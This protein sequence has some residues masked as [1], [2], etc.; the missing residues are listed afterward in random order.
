MENAN[1]NIAIV[2]SEFNMDITLQMLEV[3]KSHARFLNV[4]IIDVI[5]VPGA[6]DM[7]L[8]IKKL[9]ERNDVHGVATLGCVIK[10]ETKHDEIVVSHVARKITD[11]SLQHDKPVSLGIMGPGLMHAHAKSR[12]EKYA[13]GSIETVVKLL[14]RLY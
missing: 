9:L 4:N 13:K 8:A 2:V 6:Y 7:P 10:G 14:Q 12:I 5:F 11:L 1:M 3:A